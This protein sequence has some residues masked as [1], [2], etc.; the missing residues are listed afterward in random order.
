MLRFHAI[1]LH[2]PQTLLMKLTLIK[3]AA[4]IVILCIAGAVSES[5]TG[6]QRSGRT[7]PMPFVLAVACIAAIIGVWR[8][9]Q[10]EI[11]TRERD[12]E[13]QKNIQGVATE[14]GKS[15]FEIV[16]S[17]FAALIIIGLLIVMI[18]GAL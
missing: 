16:I 4:T 3:I 12:K 2:T 14:G 13:L 9:K 6:N 17:V 11:P 8:Y 18:K 5:I 7:G 1:F 15:A 10:E